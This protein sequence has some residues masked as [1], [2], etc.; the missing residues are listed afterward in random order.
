MSNYTNWLETIESTPDLNGGG[1][2]LAPIF[3]EL[4]SGR[5][6][7]TAF[8]W[9]AG[10]AWIGMWLLEN[11][12]CETLVT[13]DINEE[14]VRLVRKTAKT[15]DYNVRAYTSDNLK[16]IP[17]DE[18][19]DLVIS[20]PPN[21]CNIQRAH[22]HGYMRDDLRPSDIDWK[23]HKDFY[24]NIS[25][26]LNDN[27]I[28]L[29]SEVEPYSKEVYIFGELYD[30]RPE[31]PMEEFKEMIEANHLKIISKTPYNYGGLDCCVLEVHP[32]RS[33]GK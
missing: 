2:I 5:R 19:F 12:I 3:Q 9:C 16:S 21:Y 18:K 8:E 31:V 30:K 10:P 33:A 32:L 25:D 6:F 26:H 22:T 27:A 13:G 23:I 1:P 15:N 4:L 24:S 17:K 14:T 28:M 11:N 29:I 20:N 7:N